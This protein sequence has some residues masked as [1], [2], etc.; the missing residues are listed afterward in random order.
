MARRHGGKTGTGIRTLDRGASRTPRKR[1]AKNR[2]HACARRVTPDPF[3]R[4]TAFFCPPPRTGEGDEDAAATKYRDRARERREGQLGEY[5]ETAQILTQLIEGYAVH[6]VTRRCP[7]PWD[8]V[9]SPPSSSVSRDPERMAMR[10]SSRTSSPSTWVA[11]S[12]TPTSS[13]ASTM[14]CWSRS[15]SRTPRPRL[16]PGPRTTRASTSEA[17]AWTATQTG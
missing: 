11:T 10:P 1:R 15:K 16:P 12:S 2:F 14:R 4:A 6:D 13:R 17:R 8:L 7:S 9:S 3:P 5:E